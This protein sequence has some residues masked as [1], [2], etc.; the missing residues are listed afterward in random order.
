VA[1]KVFRAVP[2]VGY[3]AMQGTRAKPPLRARHRGDESHR[4]KA[5]SNDPST[6][7][8]FDEA[9]AAYRDASRKLDGI[10]YMF[11][12]EADDYVGIDLDHCCDAQT[13][14]LSDWTTEQRSCKRWKSSRSGAG[15]MRT[16]STGC[17]GG[18]S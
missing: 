8:S 7:A 4:K 2:F 3:F 15:R 5:R 9:V 16:S 17:S 18:R 6:W 13:V 1:V 14:A 10:G 12:G 11:S